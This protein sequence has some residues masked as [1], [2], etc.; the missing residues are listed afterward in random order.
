MVVIIFSGAI[1]FI[2]CSIIIKEPRSSTFLNIFGT[3]LLA[4]SVLSLVYEY[5]MTERVLRT[6]REAFPYISDP[7]ML[8]HELKIS[9]LYDTLLSL[10]PNL[11]ERE[12]LER[13]FV[14]PIVK[15]LETTIRKDMRFDITIQK[16]DGHNCV[17]A[18]IDGSY[19][20]ENISDGEICWPIPFRWTTVRIPTLDRND[21]I[22][23]DA[24]VVRVED[25]QDLYSFT[26]K[27]TNIQVL[28]SEDPQEMEPMSLE[29]PESGEF[30]IRIPEGKS[31]VV[32]FNFQVACHVE[33]KFLWRMIDFTDT[34]TVRLKYD[35]NVFGIRVGEFCLGERL[36]TPISDGKIQYEWN[37]YFLPQHGVF[38]YWRLREESVSQ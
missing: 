1:I 14:S 10:S 8:S 33:D 23:I 20:L 28:E 18:Q 30:T 3:T 5:F 27:V 35:P 13:D 34:L 15:S 6:M 11:S 12:K 32:T 22:K 38:F 7:N 2:L 37:S 25:R 31:I 19:C 36:T 17:F 9:N 29:I 16:N 24:L 21:H 4:I 26:E